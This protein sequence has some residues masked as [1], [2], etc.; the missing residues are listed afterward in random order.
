[1]EHSFSIYDLKGLRICLARYFNKTII[2]EHKLVQEPH[3]SN[4]YEQIDPKNN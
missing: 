3:V 1:M 2:S 4:K